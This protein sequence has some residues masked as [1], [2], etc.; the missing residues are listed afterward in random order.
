MRMCAHCVC[1]ERAFCTYMHISSRNEFDPYDTSLARCFVRQTE[2]HGR[3]I[4]AASWKRTDAADQRLS[5]FA[6][7]T[8]HFPKETAATI[9]SVSSATTA[10]GRERNG[11]G[12]GHGIERDGT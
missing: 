7:Y 8:S 4:I 3:L 10:Q 12:L 1:A 11:R 6:E 9:R 2:H 5:L